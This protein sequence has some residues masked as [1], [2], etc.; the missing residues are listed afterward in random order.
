MLSGCKAWHILSPL[1][2]RVTITN[3]GSLLACVCG[4]VQSMLCYEGVSLHC[5]ATGASVPQDAFCWLHV[6][7]I[8]GS[9]V[10][11]LVGWLVGGWEI[12][13]DQIREKWGVGIAYCYARDT[14]HSIS[15][16]VPAC[17]IFY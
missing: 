11:G 1:S 9:C 5:D 13:C 6:S 17:R 10:I 2:I 15:L 14:Y 12:P 3:H 4:R 7:L 8:G 16:C